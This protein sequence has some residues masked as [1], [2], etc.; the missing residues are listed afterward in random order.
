MRAIGNHIFSTTVW[1]T[2]LLL[3][4][5]C[6]PPTNQ[7]TSSSSAG[8]FS[9]GG[10]SNRSFST[11]EESK[12]DEFTPSP[13]LIAI[14]DLHGDYDA[15]IEVMRETG[16][17]DQKD[18]WSGGNAILVQTGDIADRGP[19][20]RQIITHIRELQKAAPRQGGKVITLIGNHEAMNMTGDLRYVHPGEYEAFRTRR[21]RK[22]RNRAFE[23]NKDRIIEFYRASDPE[24]SVS[25]IESKWK[26]T[27]PLGRLEH[28]AAW[29]PDGE[30]GQWVISNPMVALVHDTLFVHGGISA[31]YASLSIDEMNERARAA[32]LARDGSP[33]RIINDEK[34]PLWYRGLIEVFATVSP[35]GAV[36]DATDENAL[37]PAEE[38]SIVLSAFGAKRMVVGHT[39]SIEGILGSYDNRLIQ[40]DTGIAEYYGGVPSFLRLEYGKVYAHSDGEIIEMGDSK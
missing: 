4:L 16:L 18:R 2:I 15:Y 39:P 23:A 31:D 22:L 25:E 27:Y 5:G 9:T 8:G 6:A 13:K 20:S 24:L 38:L 7:F 21:S 33:E 12:A 37:S 14:G 32:L 35:P 3:L 36:S 40:I 19:N 11:Q 29:R 30:I 10:F 34:G 17:I 26:E 1:A 28:Q